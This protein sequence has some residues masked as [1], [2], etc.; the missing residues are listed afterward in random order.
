MINSK[1]YDR[2]LQYINFFLK[3]TIILRVEK[4]VHCKKKVQVIKNEFTIHV[5]ETHARIAI[6]NKDRDEFNQCQNQLKGL[7]SLMSSKSKTDDYRE[8]SAEFIGYR[9]L[10]NML[11][12]SYKGK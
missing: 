11:T 4:F 9:L 7:Y 6:R 1:P 2:I 12:K 3:L 5:Y 8:S 10:Y